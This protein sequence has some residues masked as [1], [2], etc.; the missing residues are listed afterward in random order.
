[1]NTYKTTFFAICPVNGIRISYSLAIRTGLVIEAEKI[2]TE[3]ESIKYGLHEDI[4]DRLLSALGG[5]QT[6]VADHHGVTIETIRPHMAH[7]AK[8][9]P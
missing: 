6:L 9:T 5:T 3:V 4:A 2:I 8:D 1:M 7:W